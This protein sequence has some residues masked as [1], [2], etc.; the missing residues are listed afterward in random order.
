MKTLLALLLLIGTV[1]G[2]QLIRTESIP[3][4]LRYKWLG[5][6]SIMLYGNNMDTFVLKNPTIDTV[7]WKPY[8]QKKKHNLGEGLTL[9]GRG[10]VTIDSFRMGYTRIPGPDVRFGG[11]LQHLQPI[12]FDSFY[13][14]SHGLIPKFKDT[15]YAMNGYTWDFWKTPVE[16]YPWWKKALWALLGAFILVVA[17]FIHALTS[18]PI[19]RN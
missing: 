16:A 1:K 17:F 11:K 15:I 12:N 6:D 3:D 2:Q 19:K 10:T 13:L 9:S 18:H 7:K 8:Y 5:R 4:T 14:S